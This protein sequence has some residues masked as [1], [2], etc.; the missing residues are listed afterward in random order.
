M[1]PNQ[2]Y[3]SVSR[4]PLD[5]EDY[6]DILRRHRSWIIGPLFAGLVISVIAAF[7]WPDTFVSTAVLR[8]TPP[9]VPERLV[10]T[11]LNLQIADRLNAMQQEILSRTSL[12]EIMQRPALD[13][14]KKERLRRPLDDV[15]EKM[16]RDIRIAILETPT[17]RQGNRLASAFQITFRYPDKY[18]AKAVVE[19][20]TGKFVDQNVQVQRTQSTS[21]TSFINDELKAAKA[22]LD[23]IDQELTTFRMQNAGRLPEQLMGNFQ[24][25]AALQQQLGGI[26]ESL[27]RN[28]QEKM[29]LE[30]SLQNLKNQVTVVA[31][32]ADDVAASQAQKSERLLQLN[33]IILDT[34]TG[35]AAARESLREDHPDIRSFKARLNVLKRERDVLQKEEESKQQVAEKP[36]KLNP[37]LTRSLEELKMAISNVETQIRA[38]EMDMQEKVKRQ[39]ALQRDIE[40]YQGRI[41]AS[42]ANEQRYAILNREYVLAKQR[43]E[44]MVQRKSISETASNLEERRWGENLEVLDSATLPEKPTEPNRLAIVAIGLGVGLIAGVFL[45]G[46]K[47]VK[48]ASLKNLKDVRAYTNL[49]V[50]SSIPLLENAL[51]V[52][53]KR[54]LLWLA[55]SSAVIVGLLA[56]SSS[57]Y[58]YYFGRA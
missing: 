58:Y 28:S 29:M 50:L 14:Y 11:N 32:G 40:A 20:L 41:Q 43:Y 34:E 7:L 25:L 27:N 46:L 47:E 23:R 15:I 48:D 35:L 51:L 19:T 18:K 44:E 52:R 16:Q 53:R 38:K 42:P 37:Q 5:V 13:L 21:T 1:V 30:N 4:R 22:N 57:M 45:A 9:Q 33:K 36:K 17:T 31:S 39:A 55:W 10:P 26:T 49:A 12:S 56:I 6:I 54:R 24:A 3:V 8:I 2:G